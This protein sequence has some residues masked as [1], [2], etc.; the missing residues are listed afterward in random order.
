MSQSVPS[1]PY[2]VAGLGEMKFSGLNKH[3]ALGGVSRAL[4][5][6]YSFSPVN[7]ASYANVKYTVYTAGLNSYLGEQSSADQLANTTYS[8]IGYFSMAFGIPNK[9][10]RNMGVSFGFHELTKV[11]YDIETGILTDTPAT[12][13]VFRGSGGLSTAYVGFAYEVLENLNLGLN[14]NYNFGNISH[15]EAIVYPFTTDYFSFSDESYDYYQG[16]NFD[17]GVQYSVQ[18]SLFHKA[19]VQHTFAATVQT[20]A[21][22]NGNGYK[23]AESFYG[24]PFYNN[25]RVIPIDTLT[26]APNLSSKKVKPLSFGVAYSISDPQHWGLSL[27]YEVNKWSGITNDLN[28]RPFFDN[29]RYSAGVFFIPELDFSTKGDFW[30]KVEYRAGFRYENLYYNFFNQQVDEIGISFG[31]GLPIVRSYKLSDE[32]ISLLNQVDLSVELMERGTTQNNLI[33]ERYIILSLGLN[34]ND[35]WFIKRKYQ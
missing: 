2:S 1:L 27:E 11:G 28:N 6:P 30:K 22:L 17:F 21:K 35:K 8:N 3:R 34:F 7:P 20:E 16:F 32:Q 31:L 23:Y 15:L 4:T 10:K 19:L 29:V 33:K 5:D 24:I 14:I 26:Y 13:K 25:G 12:Y 9:A 18:D